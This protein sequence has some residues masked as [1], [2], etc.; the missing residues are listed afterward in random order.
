ML[1]YSN[2]IQFKVSHFCD[3]IAVTANENRA[4]LDLHIL[5][6][7]YYKKDTLEI[8]SIFWSDEKNCE[9]GKEEILW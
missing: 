6:E 1:P 9:E 3:H 8:Y 7:V 5:N 4:K 2:E